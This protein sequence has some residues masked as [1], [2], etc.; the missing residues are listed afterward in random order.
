MGIVWLRGVRVQSKFLSFLIP[1]AREEWKSSF[2]TRLEGYRN[3]FEKL[4]PQLLEVSL[5][6]PQLTYL[7]NGVRI[8][9]EGQ[10]M[11]LL[12]PETGAHTLGDTLLALPK[13]KVMF[14]GDV[15]WN[16]FY[17]NLEDANLDGWIDFLDDL[18]VST[19]QKF[20]PGHG[21]IGYSRS[22][23]EFSRYLKQVRESLLAANKNMSLDMKRRCFQIPGTE[24]WK[25]K[26]IIDMNVE[27]L[28]G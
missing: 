20:V 2:E 11:Y 19:Y 17:P 16:G 18:D 4:R 3:G 9:L 25:L 13:S 24:E 27:K 23:D 21:E 28:L 1:H 26:L 10:D 22:I 12:H 15:L 5:D 14:A 8:N 7:D 6:L